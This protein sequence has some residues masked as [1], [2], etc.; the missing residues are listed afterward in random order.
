MPGFI[1]IEPSIFTQ[2]KPHLGCYANNIPH[3]CLRHTFFFFAYLFWAYATQGDQRSIVFLPLSVSP[4]LQ[5]RGWCCRRSWRTWG[6]F[7][8]PEEAP[9]RCG[10]NGTGGPGSPRS[11]G[12]AAPSTFPQ[13]RP[14]GR[15]TEALQV[16]LHTD[17]DQR[18]TLTCI[19]P[20]I[21]SFARFLWLLLL[22]SGPWECC[23]LSQ[24]P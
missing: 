2:A 7:W 21:Q 6:W 18:I 16:S 4:G 19:Y 3:I 10:T 1:Q 24:P 5:C 9:R 20:S 14:R 13:W 15:C 17:I 8:S 12:I 23:S 22:R 11:P